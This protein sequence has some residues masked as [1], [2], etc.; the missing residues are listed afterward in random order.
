M[1]DISTGAQIGMQTAGAVANTGLGMLTAGWQNKQ[2]K[3][4]MD[5][6]TQKQ[7]ELWDY[8]NAENQVEHY[9]NA[10][11]NVGLMYEKGGSGGSTGSV[12]GNASPVGMGMIDPVSAS[13]IEV[14]KAQAENLR[15]DAELKSGA[16][17]DEVVSRTQLNLQGVNN[18]KAKE[19]LDEA[20]T[21]ITKLQ[22]TVL[23]GTVEEQMQ[24]IRWEAQ[25]AMYKVGIAGSEDYVAY[26]SRDANVQIIQQTAIGKILENKL[27][28]ELTK[29]VTADIVQ[30]WR[31]VITNERNANTHEKGMLNDDYR[32]KIEADLKKQGLELQETKM[33]MDAI[34]GVLETGTNT[35]SQTTRHYTESDGRGNSWGRPTRN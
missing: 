18:G 23:E 3:K 22:T 24:Q 27:T 33:Y 15:A 28:K 35:G 29:K 34:M 19:A 20:N 25:T 30:G 32:R 9:K 7:K 5:Y 14:N 10:G 26:K 21:A 6:Q 12:S 17:T 2:Q 11:L 4:M 1:A 16:Q 8:T 13:Q 31:N